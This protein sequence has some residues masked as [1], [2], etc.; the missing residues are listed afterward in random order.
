MLLLVKEYQDILSKCTGIFMTGGN[1]LL[2]STT[3]GG[4]PVVQL[5][6]RLNAKGV[7]VAG[8]SAGIMFISGFMI[9][10]SQASLISRCNML[11]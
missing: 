11:T 8:T 3:L 6:Y 2:L 1:Q 10:G 7:N 9:A 5:I 4:T